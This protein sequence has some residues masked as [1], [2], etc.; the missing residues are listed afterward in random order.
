MRTLMSMALA[1]ICVAL[2]AATAWIVWSSYQT[3]LREAGIATENMARTLASQANTAIKI[4]DVMLDDIVERSERDGSSGQAAQRLGAHM[5]HLTERV[6]EIHGLFLYDETGAWK[7]TS[8][9]VPFKGDNS[10]RNYFIFHKTHPHSATLISAPVRSRSTGHWIIPVSRRIDHA[11]GSFAGVALATLRLDSFERVFDS[12]DLGRSGTVFFALENGTLIYRRPFQ[13]KLIGTDLSSGAVMRSYR[14]KSQT[15]TLMLVAKIDGIERLYSYRRLDSYPIIVSAALSKQD[16]F[17]PWRLASAQILGAALCAIA[18]LIW[19]FR[20]LMRQ[21]TMRDQVEMQLRAASQELEQA[22]A[23]LKT[24]AWKDGLTG[25]ANRRAF[26]GKL[27]RE[28]RRARRD[29]QPLSLILLD[30]DYFK[31]FNDAYGHVAGD[32]CLQTI[33]R[34]VASSAA[35]GEDLVARYGGEEFAVILP[36]TDSAGA[37]LVAEAVRQTV[38]ALGIVHAGSPIGL[39]TVSLG[40]ATTSDGDYHDASSTQLL[41]RADAL[42]YRSKSAGRN[43]ASA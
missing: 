27:E 35:R 7:A 37:A 34:A 36:G 5:V 41:Q 20:K 3:R 26:D 28:S 4:A 22:N 19:F 9:G 8:L 30:V 29:G 18:T 24:M 25:L 39:V 31:K 43:R 40:V 14:E 13:E 10:D 12:L 42:L 17:W 2:M 1:C 32:D 21:A 33:A 38:L 23:D 15:G 16:I 6:P 11:D